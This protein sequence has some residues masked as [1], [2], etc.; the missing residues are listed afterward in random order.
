MS[1]G[2]RIK[3][4]RAMAGLSQRELAEKAEVSAMAISKYERDLDVPGSAVLLR[5]AKSLCVAI[6]YFFRP[7]TVTLTAPTYRK[8]AS[9]PPVEEAQIL[10]RVEEWLERSL[11]VESLFDE[12]PHVD[13]PPKQSV[14]TMEEVEAVALGLR[15]RWQLGIDAIK[16]LIEILEAHGVQVGLVDTPED[17]DAL[18]LW[19]N[20]TI[21]VIVVKCDLPGDRQRFS[22]AHELAHLV[23]E[24]T[25]SLDAE[26]AARRFAG[27][28]LAPAP[29]VEAE[30]GA[31]R[32][33]LSLYELHLL[34]HKYGLSMQAWIHRARDHGILGEREAAR[35]LEQFKKRGWCLVEPG[36]ALPP[37]H[38]QRQKRLVMRALAEDLISPGRAAELLGKPLS[39]FQQQEA[40]QHGGLPV[41]VGA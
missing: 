17:F 38:P 14:G 7:T 3:A 34:K 36:D 29:I 1:I 13:L 41:A 37:E 20:T 27:G 32:R 16:G 19:A 4:A 15:E 26:T 12:A 35:L 23:L 28:F 5:L 25:E 30:L 31:K 11:E 21:P 33:A 2:A 40:E 6:E 22:L 24:P 8:R 39:Q 18:T 9:L 10:Q